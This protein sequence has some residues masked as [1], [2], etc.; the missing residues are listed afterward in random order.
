MI[1]G[2]SARPI[3]QAKKQSHLDTSIMTMPA[4]V[5]DSL[6]ISNSCMTHWQCSSICS[7]RGSLPKMAH[8]ST[9]WCSSLCQACSGSLQV[10]CTHSSMSLKMLASESSCTIQVLPA[11][12]SSQNLPLG[13]ATVT[14]TTLQG[15]PHSASSKP[16]PGHPARPAPAS[17]LVHNVQRP[18]RGLHLIQLALPIH[19]GGASEPGHDGPASG[20]QVSKRINK[21]RSTKKWV[22]HMH[23]S[24]HRDKL[25]LWRGSQVQIMVTANSGKPGYR[26]RCLSHAKRA[27]CHL[28]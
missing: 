20:P 28:S 25:I 21:I 12:S 1:C 26:S 7:T 19:Y 14:S 22:A 6:L 2:N 15:L 13:V 24:C 11:P 23:H 4:W 18:N 16:L 17:P 3:C 5:T 27:L 9:Y 10:A 8:A